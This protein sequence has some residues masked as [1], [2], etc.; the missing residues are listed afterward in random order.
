MPTTLNH[1]FKRRGG[2]TGEELLFQNTVEKLLLEVDS[3]T[4]TDSELQ[5]R[6]AKIRENIKGFIAVLTNI[7]TIGGAAKDILPDQS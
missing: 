3:L 4:A 1:D 6:F 7:A 2:F 5:P